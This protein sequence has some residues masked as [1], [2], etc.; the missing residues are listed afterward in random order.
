[1]QD[2]VWNLRDLSD[3]PDAVRNLS[4]P[5]QSGNLSHLRDAMPAAH[6]YHLQDGLRH[7]PRRHVRGLHP[8]YLWP[9]LCHT[10]IRAATVRERY[11]RMMRSSL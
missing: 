5:M 2:A 8:R 7:M 4:D 1:M 10:M 9:A 6:V 11:P 3:L